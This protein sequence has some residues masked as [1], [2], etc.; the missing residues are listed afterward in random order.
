MLLLSG[1]L[2]YLPYA[3]ANEGGKP[4][5]SIGKFYKRRILRIV[6]S[7]YLCVLIMLV[8]VALPKGSYNDPNGSFNAWRMWR[9]LL[10]HAT[11]THTLFPFSYT[12]SPLN[13]SLWTLGVEMEF[14][15]I[16]P[17][18]GRAFRRWPIATYL[19]LLAVAF[20]YRE[21]VKTMP[22]STLLF[23]Q[24][25][26]QLD[27]YANG[28]LAAGIYSALKRRMKQ[29]RWTAALFTALWLMAC[30]GIWQLV[31]GQASSNGYENIRLGQMDRRFLMSGFCALFML[32]LL[33]GCRF[34]RLIFGNRVTAF[35]SA[36]SFQ[37][38][39]YHQVFAV[40]LKEW[41]IPASMTENP[42]M[43]GEYSWQVLYT[44]LCFAGALAIAKVLQPCCSEASHAI[45]FRFCKKA[46][47]PPVRAV[48]AVLHCL[49]GGVRYACHQSRR[50]HERHRAGL[51]VLAGPAQ[52][53]GS[54]HL[55]RLLPGWHRRH[56]AD[57]RQHRH[58]E[59]QRRLRRFVPD[60]KR[61]HHLHGQQ[62]P[63]APPCRGRG[64]R[65]Q[66]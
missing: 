61:R 38:Y 29:D 55:R 52:L 53:P 27:A 13:G 9:D 23:N 8:F 35:L 44:V 36:V 2:L 59:F 18:L 28:L 26:A 58:G 48:P 41:K 3:E 15:L 51:S 64:Q 60:P 22:D 37:F 57:G 25:P 62:L 63:P 12:G 7:Y 17:F 66:N 46:A 10:A 32:G 56:R 16:F 33:F 24:L 45:Q 49:F 40:Q 4:L 39:M 34:L 31:R 19:A 11:F 65:R 50:R 47:G 1:F 21:W 43:S 30:W 14:Y 5:P 42:W 54:D 6:P 20:G